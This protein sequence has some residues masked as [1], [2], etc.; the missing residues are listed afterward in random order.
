MLLLE[1]NTI[2]K[3]QVDK[4]LTKLEFVVSTAKNT[5]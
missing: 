1:E 4:K 3:K 2:K 5:R